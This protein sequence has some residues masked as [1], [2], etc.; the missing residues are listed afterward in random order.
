[1]EYNNQLPTIILPE[2]GRHI[3][4][5][6]AHC[7][8]ITDREE[9]NACARSI[10]R[11][12][13]AIVP[14][15]GA[16]I[17]KETIYWDHLAIMSDFELDVDYPEG[18]ITKEAI[19]HE[20]QKPEYPGHFI[21]CYLGK[22]YTM[23]LLLLDQEQFTP[24]LLSGL[25]L[26]LTAS[27]FALFA[28][29]GILLNTVGANLIVRRMSHTIDTLDD[30]LDSS[31]LPMVAQGLFEQQAIFTA[32]RGTKLYQLMRLLERHEP[33]SLIKIDRQS[34]QQDITYF[35]P[36]MMDRKAA[37][38][39]TKQ[40]ADYLATG[41]CFLR[42]LGNFHNLHRLRLSSESFAAGI[43]TFL[44]SNMI[45]PYSEKV[46]SY[47]MMTI[48]ETGQNAGLMNHIV[49]LLPELVSYPGVNYDIDTLK[50]IDKQTQDRGAKF[51]SF[52]LT[53]MGGIFRIWAILLA[54][55]SLVF[56]LEM[57]INAYTS[58]REPSGRKLSRSSHSN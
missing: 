43:M 54:V 29:S 4:N 36:K 42:R 24:Q 7:K 52:S 55:S 57:V 1:M 33:D 39:L 14:E 8:T 30:L 19:Q 26:A 5:M 6:V 25:I 17:D 23:M 35:L 2:Y 56:A 37:L 10:I 53:H 58:S 27:L 11:S 48:L 21:K 12:M 47:T 28:I 9:R 49:P 46:I 16:G 50:C 31:M 3:Q 22:C 38:I 44:T 20:A 40:F 51:R 32:S 41:A 18:T 15:K 13:E 45:H 34:L